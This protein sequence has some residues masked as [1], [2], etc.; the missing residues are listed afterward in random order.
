M[1]LNSY[2]VREAIWAGDYLLATR[3]LLDHFGVPPTVCLGDAH[4][5]IHPGEYVELLVWVDDNW[6]SWSSTVGF[7]THSGAP[8]PTFSD[9][10]EVII[11]FFAP[12]WWP[13]SQ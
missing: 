6:Y 11:N 13:E 7:R 10:P 8:N 1:K 12:R 9:N 2:T 5:N 4:H 3:Y